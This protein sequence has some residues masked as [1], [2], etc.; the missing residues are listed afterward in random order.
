MTLPTK[1][2]EEQLSEA[3]R[4]NEELKRILEQ[5]DAARQKAFAEAERNA[6]SAQSAIEELQSFVYAASHDLQGPLRAVSTY[7]E[8]LHRDYAKDTQ[9]GEFIA[10]ILDGVSQM[11]A[12]IRD[13]LT[14][15]RTGKSS[16]RTNFNLTA[17]VH[18]VI[19]KLAAQIKETKAEVNY[20]ELPE[21]VADESQMAMLFENLLSNSIK[22]RSEQPPRIEIM[23]EEDGDCHVISVRDNGQGIEPRFHEQV[24]LPFKRLH[25]KNIPGTG[26]GLAISRKIIQAHGGRIWVESEGH[27]GST[28]KFTLPS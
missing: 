28:F 18:W 11:N 21:V 20:T 16:R 24:F 19:L 12:L 1:S 23:A 7:T 15:S 13:L 4:E 14:Y 17:S 6:A 10:F 27:L 2:L 3:L 5:C 25:G 9:A 22:F 8:L 26:L